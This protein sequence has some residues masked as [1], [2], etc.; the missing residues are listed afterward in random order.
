MKE[1]ESWLVKEVLYFEVRPCSS[2]G[3]QGL[4][5]LYGESI[6]TDKIGKNI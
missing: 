4:F 1:S 2:Q 6:D 3:P 5:S